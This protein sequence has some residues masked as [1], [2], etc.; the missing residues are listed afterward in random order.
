MIESIGVEFQSIEELEAGLMAMDQASLGLYFTE[1]ELVFFPKEELGEVYLLKNALIKLL[2]LDLAGVDKRQ[3]EI[4]KPGL[5]LYSQVFY[6]ELEKFI[7]LNL[8]KR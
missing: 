5:E 2:G 7:G 8:L 3:V 1:A 4:K 6:G